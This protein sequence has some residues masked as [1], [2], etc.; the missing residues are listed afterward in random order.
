M[1]VWKDNCSIESEK[2]NYILYAYTCML[3]NTTDL[4]P[5]QIIYSFVSSV[6]T[7]FWLQDLGN[8]SKTTQTYSYLF[9]L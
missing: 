4:V 2:K 6:Q 5:K 1:F 3:F 7:F 9:N 8:R